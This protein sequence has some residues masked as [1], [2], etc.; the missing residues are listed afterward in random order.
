MSAVDY[1]LTHLA[2]DSPVYTN[3]GRDSVALCGDL[4]NPRLLADDVREVECGSCLIDA[5]LDP[6]DDTL[7]DCPTV[8]DLVKA[9]DGTRATV[10]R[11]VARDVSGLRVTPVLDRRADQVVVLNDYEQEH[12]ERAIVA[13]L[14][15]E[16]D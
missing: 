1:L 14:D 10:L 16:A 4:V 8:D 13:H 6:D 3:V 2:P 15:E 9:T 11:I 12:V 5:A 7:A